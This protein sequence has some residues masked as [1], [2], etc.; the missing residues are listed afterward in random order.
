MPASRR[1]LL[2]ALATVLMLAACS[3][4]SQSPPAASAAPPAPAATAPPPVAAV[5]ADAALA[6]ALAGPARSGDTLARDAWRHPLETLTFFALAPDQTVVEVTPGGGWYTEILAPYLREHGRYIGAVIDPAKAGSDN[7]RDYYAKSNDELRARLA[8]APAAYD[9]AVLVE[10]DPQAPVFAEPGTVDRV[11][12]FRN[13]HNW[14]GNGSVAAMFRGF[15]AALKP[16]GILGVVEHRAAADVPPGDRSGYLS[17]AQVIAY[18]T[19]AGFELQDRSEINANPKD[20]RDHPNGVW[21]LPPTLRVPAGEDAKKYQ[22]IGES[23]RMTL[24]FVKPLAAAPAPAAAPAA[25]P[26]GG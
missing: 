21:T 8:A 2:A 14:I 19:A 22:E 5:P 10:V 11:L 24:R 3:D 9:R 13:V 15:H 25:E 6:A 7:A 1:P 18:A 4:A 17:E 23:D 26:A 12:T 16:G 20:T